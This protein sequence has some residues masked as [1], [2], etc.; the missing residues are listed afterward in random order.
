M[1]NISYSQMKIRDTANSFR[2]LYYIYNDRD[3]DNVVGEQLLETAN[4]LDKIIGLENKWEHFDKQ[5]II[6]IRKLLRQKG[7]L[8]E[9]I[10]VIRKANGRIELVITAKTLRNQCIQTLELAGFLGQFFACKLVPAAGS[11]MFIANQIE[12]YVMEESPD[13]YTMTGVEMRCKDGGRICGDSYSC[14]NNSDG[15]TMVCICDGM[16][17]GID[18]AKTSEVVVEM[19]EEFFEA[20]F[21]EKTA[22][23][24]INAA[25]ASNNEDNPFTLDVAVL[26]LYDGICNMVKFGAMASYIKKESAVETI[27]TYSMPAGVFDNI[28][29][30]VQSCKIGDGEYFIMVSDGVVDALPFYDKEQQ[31]ADIIDKIPTSNPKKMAEKIMDEVIFYLGNNLPDDMT[32]MV[33]GVWKS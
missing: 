32:I 2:K 25:M 20:G 7:V 28:D 4:L 11:R 22:A 10:D 13:Y 30:E 5:N 21:S 16:G 8:L 14:I 23:K 15:K 29:P 3:R 27:K 1:G 31:M 18:A 12:E 24:L 9:D 19:L 6:K 17:A 33:T 26:D